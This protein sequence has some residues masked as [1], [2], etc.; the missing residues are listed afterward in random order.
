MIQ[1][2]ENR[3]T[4]SPS[5]WRWSA[6]I[7]GIEK[8]L[9]HYDKQCV[10]TDTTIEF[11]ENDIT[12]DEY[13]NFVEYHFKDSMHHIILE[14]LLDVAE[15]SEKQI[16]I[17]NTRLSA[18][19]IMKKIF[20]G[21][22]YSK[23]TINDIKKLIEDN[24]IEIIKSTYNKGR[25]LY[26]NFC[27]DN[28]MMKDTQGSCRI[29]GY[30]V[31]VNK[32]GKSLAFR[33]DKSMIVYQD[34]KYFDFIPFA[35][36][37]SRESFFVNNNFT[38]ER[39]IA[40][41]KDEP[42]DNNRSIRSRLFFKHIESS[43]YIDYD[44]E[45]IKKERENEYFETIFVNKKAIDI[46]SQITEQTGKAITTPCKV[47]HGF[48]MAK[49]NWLP[50]ENIVVDSIL[51]HNKLDWLLDALLKEEDK[52]Y[53]IVFLIKINQL[54]YKENEQMTIKQKSAYGSAMEVKKVLMKKSNKIRSYEQKLIS[55]L[56]LKD[57]D[58]VQEILLHLSAFTQVS[59]GFLTDVFEDFEANKNLVYTFI[60][61]LGEKQ[62]KGDK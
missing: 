62:Y 8:Y 21:I 59:M 22:K 33:R 19:S 45:I 32:K 41:N 40:S 51:N 44:V 2:L 35:F 34:N 57:Y 12:E 6:T 1:R 60:N 53:W 37:K 38:I 55:A 27:N 54:I 5:D 11:D 25:S 47:S 10:I 50:I 7:V 56:S 31:D 23:S 28:A 58:K 20:K 14:S 39:L 49:D 18:N 43:S 29:K 13:F 46:F 4:I 48:A 26:Y 17:I 9:N 3:I 24:R 30:S 16:K 36:S 42:I 15:P 61:T 52:H